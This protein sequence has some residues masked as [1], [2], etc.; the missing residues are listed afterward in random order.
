MPLITVL[1]IAVGLS[2]DAFAVAIATGVM[3]KRDHFLHALRMG[4][5]FGLFQAL[6]PLIGWLA[7][8]SVRDFI[9]NVDHWIAFGLLLIIGAKMIYE[10]WWI[11]K[12]EK[13][14]NDGGHGSAALLMLSIATSI[15]ALAVGLSLSLVNVEVATPSMIIG[16][17]TFWLTFA[18]VWLGSRIGHWFEDWIEVAGGVVLIGIGVKILCEHL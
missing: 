17:T 5:F 11:G 8:L 7:G 6:M 13:A 1:G 2:M 12:E 14:A 15:D 4:V 9:C 18:G 16:A 3:L 10:S